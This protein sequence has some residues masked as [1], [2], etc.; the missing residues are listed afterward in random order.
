MPLLEKSQKRKRSIYRTRVI[1]ITV[2]VLGVMIVAV[3]ILLASMDNYNWM[4]S[5]M[6]F[7]DQKQMIHSEPGTQK[8][9]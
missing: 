9:L 4:R 8:I 7:P 6:S 5:S 1:W 3:T 2:I